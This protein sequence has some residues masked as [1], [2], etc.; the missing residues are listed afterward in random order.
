MNCRG[1]SIAAQTKTTPP[2]H[3]DHDTNGPQEGIRGLRKDALP[4][5]L[6]SGTCI[7]NDYRNAVGDKLSSISARGRG[8]GCCYRRLLTTHERMYR[9]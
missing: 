1:S 8:E 5:N 9:R 4:P 6:S 3:H 2:H 7:S